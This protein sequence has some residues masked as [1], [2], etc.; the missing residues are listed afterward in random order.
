MVER[1]VLPAEV[2]KPLHEL[3]SGLGV[4]II[5]DGQAYGFWRPQAQR[6]EMGDIIMAIS[7]SVD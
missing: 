4:R 6:L 2:G 5:R 7:P 1:D 3:T